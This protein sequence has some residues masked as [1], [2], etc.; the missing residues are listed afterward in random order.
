MPK[1]LTPL[2][3]VWASKGLIVSFKLETDDKLL[4]PKARQ[5]L[6]RYGHQVVVANMLHTRK[7]TVTVI[8]QTSQQVISLTQEDLA[9][10]VEIEDRIIPQL[11]RIH[12]GWI[13]SGATKACQQ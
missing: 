12:D 2:V 1:F 9:N 7:Q 4:V 8:T 13:S 10:H 11:K 6:T 5:A 3:S